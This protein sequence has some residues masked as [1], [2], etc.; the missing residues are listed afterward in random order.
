MSWWNSYSPLPWPT[1]SVL[2]CPTSEELVQLVSCVRLC[3]PTHCNMPSFPVYHQFPELAQ[4]HVHR[5][6]DAIQPSHPLCPLLLPSIFPNI[7]AFS[8]ELVL[9][10]RWPKYWSF[11]FSISPSNE[12]SGLISFRT[13]RFDLL[14]VQGSLK[15]PPAP[16]F[17]GINS[18]VL[19]FLYGPTLTSIH[20]YWKNHS[21]DYTDLC[22]LFN[23]LSRFFIAFFPRS[24]CLNFMAA[25]TI[26]N[27]FG[28]QE[29]KIC[30]YLH[31]FPIY[32]PWSAGTGCHDLIFWVLSFKPTFSLSSFTFIKRL[33]SSSSLS[34]IKVVSS[35]YLRLLIFLP[36]ILI[37]ACASAGL[38]FLMMYSTY[39]LNKQ[40]DNTQPWHTPSPI[41]DQS[42]V[43]C[44]VLTVASWPE[45]R[46]LRRQVRWSGIPISWKLFQF[47][48]IHIVKGFSVVNEAEVD[49]FFLILLLFLWSS[50]C[51]Q[52]DLWF[53]C[54]F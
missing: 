20:D 42:I 5:V 8:K 52:F 45:Y 53:L 29:N 54:L 44:P 47:V 6:N 17:K 13:D 11:S 32:L 22:L 10:I 18:L 51:W 50:G 46:F 43:P 4:T 14:A 7:R 33:F 9:W 15:S 1:G 3:D 49:F 31:C 40:G 25:V 36:A 26:C 48:V 23:M 16:Q 38:A 30:H 34:A 41:W 27:V 28:A 12:Y 21:F 24:K 37:P 19:S 39:K 2:L 35:T